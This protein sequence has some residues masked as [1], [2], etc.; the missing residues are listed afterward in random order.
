MIA[1]FYLVFIP[2]ALII[3]LA[4]TIFFR[5]VTKDRD[6]HLRD[7]GKSDLEIAQEMERQENN[8]SAS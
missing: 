4:L 6:S 1:P 7:T 3:L 5:C 2:V 8:G